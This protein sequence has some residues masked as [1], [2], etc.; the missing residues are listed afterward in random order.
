MLLTFHDIINICQYAWCHTEQT[1]RQKL[2]SLYKRPR[3]EHHKQDVAI[4]LSR[5]AIRVVVSS[6]L[7]GGYAVLFCFGYLPLETACSRRTLL[8]HIGIKYQLS[9]Q[10]V[11]PFEHY[12]HDKKFNICSSIVGIT[13]KLQPSYLWSSYI[14]E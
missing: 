5:Q 4:K 7:K 11:D 8:S 3:C 10:L 1:I 9:H 6:Y 14:C 12:Y 13:N 2:L